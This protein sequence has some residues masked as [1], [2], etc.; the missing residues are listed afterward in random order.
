MSGA[1]GWDGLLAPGEDILWQGQPRQQIEWRAL[2]SP[3]TAM[4]LIFTGFSAFWISMAAAMTQGTNAPA[5]FQFFPLFGVPFFLLGLWMLGG[6]VL[7]PAFTA[8]QTWYTLTN[9]QVFI[10]RKVLGKRSLKRWP[11]RDLDRILL[12]EGDPGSVLFRLKGSTAP[13]TRLGLHR[14]DEA[15]QVYD[16]LRNAQRSLREDAR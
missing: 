11:I 1:G 5:P 7:W 14:I 6:R 12:R 4:G 2:I 13:T 8:G 9:R 3:L 15:R 10:A 16:L